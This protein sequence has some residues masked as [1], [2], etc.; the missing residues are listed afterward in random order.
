MNQRTDAQNRALH[1]FCQQVAD[2]L[3][4]EGYDTRAFLAKLPS[5]DVPLTKE[6]V[7]EALFRT[8]GRRMFGKE[9]TAD[10]TKAELD[11]ALDPIIKALGERFGVEA[12]FPHDPEKGKSDLLEG[13]K[14]DVRNDPAYP[15]YRAPTF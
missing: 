15:E 8:V 10:W 5:I 12:Q 2:E 6:I 11:R 13:M 3:N 1:L 4:N 14:A 7:K 9:H